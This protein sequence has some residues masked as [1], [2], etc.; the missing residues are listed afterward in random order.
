MNET[1]PQTFGWTRQ[2]DGTWE[3]IINGASYFIVKED[4]K[5]YIYRQPGYKQVDTA[6]N[7]MTAIQLVSKREALGYA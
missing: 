2:P 4:G 3:G 5:Y 6:S 7:L 1:T